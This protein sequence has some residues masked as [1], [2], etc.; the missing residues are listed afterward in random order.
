MAVSALPHSRTTTPLVTAT[1]PSG[2]L[3]VALLAPALDLLGMVQPITAGLGLALVAAIGSAAI[4]LAYYVK[5]PRTSW[6]AAAALAATAS[7]A[8]RIAGVEFGPALSVLS[9]IALGVGGAFASDAQP[10]EIWST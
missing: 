6:L 1:L 5:Y 4:L 8:L 9:V 3:L 2:V 10:S 7:A